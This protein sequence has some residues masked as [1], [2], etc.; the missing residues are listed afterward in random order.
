[1]RLV[2]GFGVNDA[3][4]VVKVWTELPKDLSGKRIRVIEWTCPFYKTWVGM[5][6]RCYSEQSLIKNPTYKNV[7]VC[8]EWKYFSNFK[9]WMETQD[10]E[11]KHLDKDIIGPG[12]L[13]SS[14][15]CCF[16]SARV[17]LFLT[18]REAR[19]NVAIGVT[20]TPCGNYAA[21]INSGIRGRTEYLGTYINPTDA[22]LAWCNAKLSAAITLIRE[23]DLLPTVACSLI[24]KVLEL[25]GN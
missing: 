24:T 7:S 12:N 16:V 20:V 23:E 21:K 5:I 3:K 8:E 11:G 22:H 6:H 25:G 1:M 18:A 15:C 4:Y 19:R 14:S 17:N 13:Y 2:R 10:W 9:A